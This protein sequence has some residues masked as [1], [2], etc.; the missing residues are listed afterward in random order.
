[1]KYL[2]LVLLGV[3]L[4]GP[5]LPALAHEGHAKDPFHQHRLVQGTEVA[6]Q[7]MSVRAYRQYLAARK[8]PAPAFSAPYVL[9]VVLAHDKRWLDTRVKLKITDAEGQSVGAASGLE[10]VKV[11]EKTGPHYAFPVALQK[12]QNYLVMVQF[13]GRNGLQRAGFEIKQLPAS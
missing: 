3:L 10:P 7:L 12:Q 6:L 2:L 8:L 4:S 9:L 13:A 1:M 5:V 11:S